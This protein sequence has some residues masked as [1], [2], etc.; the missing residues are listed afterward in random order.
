MTNEIEHIPDKSAFLLLVK[1][2]PPQEQAEYN[3]YFSL[4]SE[5]CFIGRT[6]IVYDLINGEPTNTD[7]LRI[8]GFHLGENSEPVIE[9]SFKDDNN[10][11][12]IANAGLTPTRYRDRELFLSVPQRFE[13]R[14]AGQT[15]AGSVSFR[16][17]F[18]ILI[19]TRSRA[20]RLAEGVTGCVTPKRFQALFPDY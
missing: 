3:S 17:H 1:Q 12:C 10:Q 4:T 14:W 2:M 18:A 7:I 13:F 19:K 5:A 20:D 15:Q 6:F 9:Y 11:R 16:P 8:H